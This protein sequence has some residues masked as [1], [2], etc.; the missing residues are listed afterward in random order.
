LTGP[1]AAAATYVTLH[2]E[3]DVDQIRNAIWSGHDVSRK[4][5]RN[6]LAN[7]RRALGEEMYYV[8]EGRLAAGEQCVPTTR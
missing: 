3:A 8:A 2:R 5:V 6:V 7:V 1:D 4:R